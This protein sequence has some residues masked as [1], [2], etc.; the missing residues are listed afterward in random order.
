MLQHDDTVILASL[1]LTHVQFDA[2]DKI[3]YA[4][5]YITLLPLAILVFYAS[6]IVS[7]REMAGILM[8]LGQL[9]NEALNAILKEYLQIARPHSHLGTG[10]GMPSSHAQFMAFFAVYGSLYLWSCMRLDH[11]MYKV[12]ATL[13]MVSLSLLVCYSRIY[14]EYHSAMQVAAGMGVG[15]LYGLLWHWIL[16]FVIRPSGI[17]DRLLDTPLAKLFYLRDMRAID[18]VAR[19][20]YHQWLQQRQKSKCKTK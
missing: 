16:E 8:L 1:S 5:A 18:N 15:S 10:Y 14:L 11:I 4:F 13:G 9:T 7:R 17:I 2:Q 20:E 6:V 3:A 12:L 19:W